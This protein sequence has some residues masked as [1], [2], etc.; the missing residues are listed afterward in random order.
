MK[1]FETL[2]E[3]LI[4]PESGFHLRNSIKAKVLKARRI[5]RV[6]HIH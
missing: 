1:I 2:I 5:A 4:L 6:Q 3:N